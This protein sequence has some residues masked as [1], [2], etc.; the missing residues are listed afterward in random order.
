[1]TETIQ[2][3]VVEQVGQ[4][5]E[6][7]EA[8][9]PTTLFRTDDPAE[10]VI[11]ATAIA[12]VL[13]KVLRDKK[14]T[15]KIGKGEHVLVE[16]WTLLGTMLGVF[17]ICEWT[18]KLTNPEGWE[19][20]VIVKTLSGATVGAAEA[21]C[22]RSENMWGQ[23]DDYALRSMAQTR[24]TSKALR[25]PLGFVV[26]LAGFSATPAEEMPREPERKETP[27]YKP[28]SW[29]QLWETLGTYGEPVTELW[30]V[31]NAQTLK[32]E[33]PEVT[34]DM[35]QLPKEIK[36]K[37]WAYNVDASRMLVEGFSPDE[38]PPPTVDD[39]RDIWQKV[40][41]A[42]LAGPVEEAS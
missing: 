10:V 31:F 30:K 33:H 25:Q 40:T 34:E 22:L 2:G 29:K 20:R 3:E 17:P 41:G 19:A 23:R 21:E 6:L 13:S 39:I 28:S 26:T 18:R 15:V 8:P 24:A 9:P 5:L 4:A 38:L 11:K 32:Y 35:K 14:L 42:E 36:D 12:N 37:L 16:G 1:M 7:A 27:A